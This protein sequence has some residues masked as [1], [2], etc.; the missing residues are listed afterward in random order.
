MNG[1]DHKR[2]EELKDAYVLGALPEEERR[3]FK[4]YLAAH[5]ERRAETEELGA[6][7]ALLALSPQE[8]EPSAELR[9]RVMAT[10]EAEAARPPASR[11][12]PFAWIRESLSARNFALGAAA[13]LLVI[14]L[15]SWSMLLRGEVQ[16][17]QGR[18]QSL[19][20]QPQEPQ[21]VE[22]GGA[23][24]EQ[25]ARAELVTLQG[26]R[27]VLVVENMP[28]VPEDKTYQIWVIE[29]DVPKPG[30]LFKPRGDS[31]AAVVEHP[32][33]GGDVIAVTV[34]P[35]GGSPKPTSKPML[36]A[37]VRT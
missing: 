32:L 36:A 7:A 17:L 24:T 1:M 28:P 3:K 5:P 35:E 15:F 8:H 26:D 23:G 13:A 31:V 2:F 30:G 25:G 27:A 11:R 20:G 4:E 9:R 29:D 10:V 21:M 16:D 12:S 19:Q 33:G 37:E 18:V 14:G 22:L 6:V 34:E